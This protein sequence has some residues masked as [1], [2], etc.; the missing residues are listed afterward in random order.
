MTGHKFDEIDLK[1]LEILQNRGQTKRNELAE[2]VNLSIPSV[3][4]RIRKLTEDGFIESVNTV[5]T[6]RKVR[7]TVTAFIFL[8]CEFPDYYPKLIARVAAFDEI[9]ECHAITG[10]G[11]HLLKVRTH[12]TATLEKLLSE[13]QSWAGVKTTRTNVVLS[14]HKETTVLPLD[15]LLRAKSPVD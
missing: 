6:P 4:E 1:I 2:Q 8:T 5:L 11:S 3:S 15:Y 12:D 7:L 14:T 9:L 10:E 13:I